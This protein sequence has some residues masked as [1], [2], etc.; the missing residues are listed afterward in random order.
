MALF[1][2]PATT[3]S[4][5]ACGRAERRFPAF[6]STVFSRFFVYLYYLVAE[7]AAMTSHMS[8]EADAVHD[9]SSNAADGAREA[10]FKRIVSPM[11][12]LEF[13]IY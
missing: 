1:S 13:I 3:M 10:S 12:T 8:V 6:F 2:L 5:G 4:E 9:H 11:L 7:V